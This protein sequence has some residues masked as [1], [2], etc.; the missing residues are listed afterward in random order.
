MIRELRTDQTMLVPKTCSFWN[1]SWQR[2]RI[3]SISLHFHG[4]YLPIK[5][6]GRS[7][8][9]LAW[10]RSLSSQDCCLTI[11]L[12]P[13]IL[14]CREILP[15]LIFFRRGSIGGIKGE[16]AVGEVQCINAS[17]LPWPRR[18]LIHLSAPYVGRYW[19]NSSHKF[20]EEET[21]ASNSDPPQPAQELFVWPL[22]WN[23]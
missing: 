4:S 12:P 15:L 10:E 19:L 20:P 21:M 2:C 8:E 17:F 16:P 18:T 3:S 22:M 13:L 7:Q 5:P 9:V 6:L 1:L 23:R 11:R 14:S